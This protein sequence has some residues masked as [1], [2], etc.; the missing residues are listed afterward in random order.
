[1]EGGY[2]GVLRIVALEACHVLQSEVDK[3]HRRPLS[4]TAVF[5]LFPHDSVGHVTNQNI[6]A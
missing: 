2:V 4:R 6:V 5:D 3:E 1:M